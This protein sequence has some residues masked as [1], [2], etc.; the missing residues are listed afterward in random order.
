MPTPIEIDVKVHQKAFSR[1]YDGGHET[2]CNEAEKSENYVFG[3]QWHID[4]KKRMDTQ[5]KPTLTINK[6]LP[7]VAAIYGEWAS[8]NSELSLQ[9]THDDA[10]DNATVLSKV[11][12]HCLQRCRYE[13]L[14][15]E[16]ALSALITN[17]GF[18][19]LTLDDSVDPSGEI[20]IEVVI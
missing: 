1:A 8:M 10:A 2:Y 9:A 13:D 6:I 17:R 12:K 20:K 11:I 7:A 16:Q 5:R 19:R 14:K 18:V 15:N 3:E 4:D